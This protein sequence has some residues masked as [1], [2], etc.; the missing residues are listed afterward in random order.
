LRIDTIE[1]PEP[2]LWYKGLEGLDGNPKRMMNY[3]QD[4]MVI[5]EGRV[6]RFNADEAQEQVSVGNYW[7]GPADPSHLLA[8]AVFL[9]ARGKYPDAPNSVTLQLA[10][11]AMEI[12]VERLRSIIRWH[13]NYTR[14]SSGD[15]GY[16]VL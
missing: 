4:A 2:D 11:R 6:F 8:V 1:Y 13:E 5:F 9:A 16:S 15:P 12:T 14:W 3:F 7:L 10:A